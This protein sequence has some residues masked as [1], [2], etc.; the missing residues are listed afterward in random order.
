[1][2]GAKCP[3]LK[4]S[5]GV[6]EAFPSSTPSSI[7]LPQEQIAE[8]I[9]DQDDADRKTGGNG[10]QVLAQELEHGREIAPAFCYSIVPL[11]RE[12]TRAY[13]SFSLRT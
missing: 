7:F 8:P 10:Q 9:Q 5:H 12:A 3:C 4:F 6:G 13:I 1:M 11:A 2:T